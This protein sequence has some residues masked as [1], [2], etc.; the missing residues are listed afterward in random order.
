MHLS[1]SVEHWRPF[2]SAILFHSDPGMTYSNTHPVAHARRHT[3]IISYSL[4]T[5][6]NLTVSICD[7]RGSLARIVC[8]LVAACCTGD[9]IESGVIRNSFVFV[10]SISGATGVCVC[11]TYVVYD[12]SCT[13]IWTLYALRATVV[14]NCLVTI[15]MFTRY[16]QKS[17]RIVSSR[18]RCLRVT[19]DGRYAHP[20][21]DRDSYACPRYDVH[22]VG[23]VY[24]KR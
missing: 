1:I 9:G 10:S 2:R 7:W 17:L 5:M 6:S 19:R 15:A 4:L 20:R 24:D 21:Y 16:A 13:R 23:V 8:L 3:L 11:V 14:A 12:R 22:N 18:S